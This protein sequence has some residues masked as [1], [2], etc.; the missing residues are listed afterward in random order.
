MFTDPPLLIERI[1]RRIDETRV[2]DGMCRISPDAPGVRCLGELTDYP[3]IIRELRGAGAPEGILTQATPERSVS[4]VKQRLPYLRKIRNTGAYWRF[5]RIINDLYDYTTPEILESDVDSLDARVAASSLEPQ[6]AQQILHERCR[7]ERIACDLGNRSTGVNPATAEDNL[8]VQVNYF[9]DATRLLS[10][11]HPSKNAERHVTKPAY[12]SILETTIGSRP[13]SLAALNR[14]V[15][16]FLD[17]TVTGQV[18]FINARI[19]TRIRLEPADSG[20]IDSLLARES[21]GVP[22]T[23]DETDQIGSAVGAA[24]FA[25]A[26]EHRR[27]IV[28]QGLGRS[29]HQPYGC[30]ATISR[31]AKSFRGANLVLADYARDFAR[32]VHHLAASHPNIALAGF[33]DSTFVTSLIASEFIER[34]Q[35][36]PIGKTIGFAS[37]APNVEWLYANFQAVRY[38]TA[39]GFVQAVEIDHLHENRIHDLLTDSLGNSVIEF[40]GL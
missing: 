31:L 36:V 11:D 38:G 35:V 1:A 7:I 21:G 34:L 26:H 28:M 8:G 16:D 3:G 17:R 37:L 32:H 33:S 24:I 23:D 39:Q 29:P 40:L 2:S 4:L 6:W 18:R 20:A 25:W 19:S 10:V 13:A 27:T 5:M 22:L 30:P 14:G 12:T 15:G 9:W